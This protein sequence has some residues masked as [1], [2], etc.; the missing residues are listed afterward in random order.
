MGTAMAD[1]E[2]FNFNRLAGIIAAYKGA[3]GKDAEAIFNKPEYARLTVLEGLRNVLVHSSGRVDRNFKE[4]CDKARSAYGPLSAIAIG[5]EIPLDGEMAQ[6]F[7]EL[8]IRVCHE[9]ISLADVALRKNEA[10]GR[11]GDKPLPA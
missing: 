7:V 2:K 9:P 1:S 3:F 11:D 8:T 5:K 10:H 4:R 6:E